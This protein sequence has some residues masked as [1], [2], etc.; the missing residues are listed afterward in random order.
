M[1]ELISPKTLVMGLLAF[2]TP[3]A[4]VVAMNWEDVSASFECDPEIGS[5]VHLYAPG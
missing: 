1:E 2:L 4:C 3:A 5:L